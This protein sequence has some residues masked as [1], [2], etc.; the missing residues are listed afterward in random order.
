MIVCGE[1]LPLST[2]EPY[3]SLK[4]TAAHTGLVQVKADQFIAEAEN[5]ESRYVDRILSAP[6]VPRRLSGKS[7]VLRLIAVLM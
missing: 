2:P 7:L 4:L 5:A 1:T 3:S 6:R